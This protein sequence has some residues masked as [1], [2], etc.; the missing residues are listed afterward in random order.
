[1]QA[2][3]TVEGLHIFREFSQPTSVYRWHYVNAEKK[4]SI[5][6]IKYFLK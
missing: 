3:D 5:A 6:F 2:R 1:M 4:S